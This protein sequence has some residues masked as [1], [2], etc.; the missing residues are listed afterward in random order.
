[1][2]KNELINEQENYQFILLYTCAR[3]IEIINEEW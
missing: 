2:N 1:M 3:K